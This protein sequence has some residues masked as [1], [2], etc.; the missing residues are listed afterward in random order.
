MVHLA[1]SFRLQLI[2]VM[3]KSRNHVCV[4]ANDDFVDTISSPGMCGIRRTVHQINNE[5]DIDL[6][7]NYCPHDENTFLSAPRANRLTHVGQSF[8]G[9]ATEFRTVLCKYAV[10]CGFEFKYLKN[11]TVRI[12]AVCSLRESKGCT[13]LV[14]ERVL[15][16]NGFFYLRKWN[17]Q[18]I[19][20]VVVRTVNNRRFGSDLVS[21]IFAHRIRDKPL[22]RPTDVAFDLKKNYGLEISC[23][24]VWLGVEKARDELFGAQS[25]SFDQLRWYSGAV[26]EHNLGTYINIDCDEHDNRFERFFISFKACIDGFKHCRPSLFLDGTFLKGRFKGN[27]LAATSKDGNRGLFPV[28]F[29]IVGA[30]NATN[31]SWFLQHLRNAL[32]D[33]RTFTFISDRHV[34][35][36]EAMPI[37]FPNAHHAF[38][39][40]HL[41]RNLKDKLKYMNNFHRIALITKFNNCAYAPIVTAFEEMVE[42]FTNSGKKITIDFLGNLPPQ[43]WANAYFRCVP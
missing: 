41:Q 28:A 8:E 3:V 42:K 37:I 34:G 43:H 24:V 22:T 29:A 40:Q 18:H 32:G 4:T 1:S 5:C 39:M 15:D 36:M 13:W 38:C 7:P 21:D 35:L 23:R 25:A 12:T 33:D 27:L 31:W 11:D 26:T 9:G 19:C 2:E 16:A 10:E 6:L 30:E 20:G 17:S 14:H